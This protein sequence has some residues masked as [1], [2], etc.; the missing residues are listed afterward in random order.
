[1]SW[2]SSCLQAFFLLVGTL[3]AACCCSVSAPG[4][5]V[6]QCWLPFCAKFRAFPV[7]RPLL[8]SLL[9]DGKLMHHKTSSVN[10][11]FISRTPGSSLWIPRNTS[12]LFLNLFTQAWPYNLLQKCN[13]IQIYTRAGFLQR[14]CGDDPSCDLNDKSHTSK[15]VKGQKEP[16]SG[17]TWWNCLTKSWAACP[18][19]KCEKEVNLNLANPL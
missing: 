16:W 12:S 17:V 1:M 3:D 5:L 13:I 7:V 2:A 10:F 19:F 9:L 6:W 4:Y 15:I 14:W 8:F 18:G 11:E